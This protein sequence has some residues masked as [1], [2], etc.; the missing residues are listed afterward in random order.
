MARKLQRGR[1]TRSIIPE[2]DPAGGTASLDA[3]RPS[4]LS[5]LNRFLRVL[6]PGLIT[7]ASDDDPSGIG[8]YAIAGASFGFNTLW[9]ALVTLPMMASVQYVRQDWNG[10]GSRTRRCAENLLS[11]EPRLSPCLPW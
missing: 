4:A 9:M 6:G 1:G 10:F 2:I 11:A 3:A 5:S 8:T 7:G